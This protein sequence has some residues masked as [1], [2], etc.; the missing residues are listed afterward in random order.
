MDDT[1]EIT[2]PDAAD[3]LALQP[4]ITDLVA[5][6]PDLHAL[7]YQ[8]A[9]DILVQHD[10]TDIEPDKVYWHRFHGAQSSSTAFTGWQHIL[11]KPKESMTFPQLVM[12]RFSVHD[13]DNA[14][15]LDLRI[16]R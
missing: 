11:E 8:V 15:L 16:L 10:I 6:C 9:K 14:D 4:L 3:V 12:Q 7:A 5:D 13:Q 1:Q 2:L